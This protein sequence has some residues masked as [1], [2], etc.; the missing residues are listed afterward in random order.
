MVGWGGGGGGSDDSGDGVSV[1]ARSY[2]QLIERQHKVLQEAIKASETLPAATD[3][4]CLT[5]SSTNPCARKKERRQIIR[6]PQN[7]STL[8]N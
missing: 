3:P 5:S 8:R 7:P 2:V 1:Q 4:W 6:N